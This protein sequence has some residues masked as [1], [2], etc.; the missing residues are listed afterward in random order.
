VAR[1]PIPPDQARGHQPADRKTDV[2]DVYGLPFRQPFGSDGFE[3]GD[4]DERLRRC[5]LPQYEGGIALAF[6]LDPAGSAVDC[7]V[8]GRGPSIWPR[9]GVA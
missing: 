7:L 6:R 8:F 5:G 1:G 2:L 4:F 9:V 3:S